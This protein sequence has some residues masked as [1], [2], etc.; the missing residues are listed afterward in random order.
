MPSK[1][2]V[3]V[4]GTGP[5][6]AIAVDALVQEQAFDVVRVFERQEKAGGC[7]ISRTNETAEPLDIDRLSTRSADAPI[8][9][10]S[11]LP[12]Y[13]PAMTQHRYD[14]A[15]IYPTLHTNVDASVMEYSQEPIPAI[16]SDTSVALHGPDTPFRHHTVI[17]QY[18][19]DLLNRNG[20]QDLV[21]YNTTVERAVKDTTSGKWVLTLRRA[22]TQPDGYDY[23]WS[24]TFD[25]LVVASGH[26]NVPYVPAIPGLK[27]F[28]QK[29]P[30]SV[31]HAKQYRGPEKYR[32]KKVITVGAS[33][34]AADTAV[35]LIGAAQDPIIAVVRGKYNVYF[36]DEAFKHPQIQRRPPISHVASE[37]GQ[38]TVHFE[39]GTSVSDVDHIIFGTG[40]TWTL[41]FLPDI[42]IRNNRVPDLYLHVFHQRDP[43]LVFLGAV[44]AGLTFKVFEWQA[45]AAARVLAGKAQLPPLTEQQKWETDRIAVKG[46]GPGFL[47]V[48]PDFKEYFEKLRTLAGEPQ[49]GAPGRRLPPFDQAWVDDFNA[50]HERRIR[51]WQRANR[52]G[53]KTRFLVVPLATAKSLWSNS[54]GDYGNLIT[55]AFPLGNGRLGAMPVGSYGKEIVNLN[56]DSLWRGGPFENPEYSGGNPNK[57]RA[58][59]LPDIRD[60]IFQN[61][62]GNVS[63]LLGEFPYYGSYQVLGNLTIDLGE[64]QSVRDYKRSL[65][66]PSGMYADGFVAGNTMYNRTAF[67]SYPDQV[68]VYHVV[69]TNGLLP[70]IRIELEN[71]VVSPTPNVSCHANS[72]SLYGQTF[73]AIG[74]IYNARASVV[75]PGVK[76]SRDF[77]A[78]SAVEV[79]SGQKEVYIVLAADT[80][81]DPS[82]GNAASKFS[83]RGND[84]SEKVQRIA[85][86][87]ADKSYVHLKATHVKDFRAISEGFKLNLPDPNGSARRPTTEL[88]ASYTQPGDPFVESLLFDYG[89]YLFMSSSRPGSLPPNLQGL[90][91]E[92][93]SPAWSADY[94]ANIN[95]QMNHW[96]VEQ[97]GLGELTQ[98]LW[99]YMAET[100]VPRGQETARLLY[101]GEGWVTHDEMNIFGH[102]AM[103]NDAQWAN[104][105]AVN[106]WMSTHIWDHFDYTQDVAWYRQTGYPIL[107]GAAQFWL[108]QLVKDKHFD[109]G[110]WVVNPCNSPE[111]GPTTFGCTNYQQLIWELFDHVLRG[112]SASGDKDVSFRR[113][114]ASRFAALDTGIHIGS[115]G[116][117]Q[118]WKLDLDTPNDT[119]RHL[120][121]LHGW[122]P[123]YSMHALDGE[124]A[125]VSRAVA[126]TLKSR[127]D[128]V[129]DQNTGWAK[130]W[131]SACWALLNETE[132]AYSM[133]TLAVQNNFAN[134]GLSMYGGSTPFQIDANFGIMGA[135]AS[136]L[137]RDLDRTSS[138]TAPR[139]VLGPAIPAAWAGGSVEGLRLRGGGSVQFGWDGMGRVTWCKAD[140]SKRKGRAPVFMVEDDVID[141]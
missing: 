138:Q 99:E 28:A 46:D 27:E 124:Y 82:K 101:G 100:W 12:A 9:L 67:C 76:Q 95:L 39:D 106:A 111:H 108:S 92:Q 135:I 6:G 112:W 126:T 38:R 49:P 79:P 25:A 21:E 98:P 35:S 51:M 84:P 14:D 109:D 5:S 136:L 16:R 114:V 125:N 13:L 105:P 88:I 18:I 70:Y 130:M 8:P 32:G 31:E 69:S 48:N 24:E 119:H 90:W 55:T 102:T 37:N 65:D 134:N 63:A 66:L 140:L 77:C 137:V 50:G 44:G 128:G 86:Q 42:P 127:G 33:V 139:V 80:N 118:E 78:G 36:G 47:M 113:T 1:K 116:Q 93:E 15:H 45:V 59:S 123:G 133:L 104:Y 56:V 4:I 103:K 122:Y 68:C 107:K 117:I 97:V 121:N 54:P 20:Y 11:Q 29:Y 141:C 58:V 40:F 131:R 62:T 71:Q 23:W 132:M 61:G 19:E 34:S 85:S 26:Y 41:P 30:G 72:I 52:E 94:H 83:F 64:L 22:G 87:A 57:S 96:A 73:P 53:Q 3:A 91:T 2:S 81:Y 89:R 110:T 43:S 10:P 129:A 17:R 120:S 60:F 74:M 7:W 115:W 75:F